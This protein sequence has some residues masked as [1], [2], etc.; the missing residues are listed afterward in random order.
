MIEKIGTF[1]EPLRI[2]SCTRRAST[3]IAREFALAVKKGQL[4]DVTL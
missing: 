4:C 1:Q 3:L 2:S